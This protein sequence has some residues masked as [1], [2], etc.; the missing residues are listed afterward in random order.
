[1]DNQFVR[2][3]YKDGRRKDIIDLG[4]SVFKLDYCVQSGHYTALVLPQEL[5]VRY[6]YIML[7][8]L[9]INFT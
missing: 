2:I 7:K 5:R 3:F 6:K 1:M 9:A 8:S 4:V